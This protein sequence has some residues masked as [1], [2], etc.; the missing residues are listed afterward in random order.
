VFLSSAAASVM[1]LLL[2]SLAVIQYGDRSKEPALTPPVMEPVEGMVDSSA[3][4]G[5]PGLAATGRREF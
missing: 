1:I 2:S 4:G 3:S 5:A